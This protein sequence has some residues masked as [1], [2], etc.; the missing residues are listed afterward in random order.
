MT[1]DDI[2][3]HMRI[4]NLGLGAME[5][6]IHQLHPNLQPDLVR[7]VSAAITASVDALLAET[8][9]R[10]AKDEDQAA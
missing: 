1:F 10:P 4:I 8:A 3:T 5:K 7:A 9:P 6:P 2:E